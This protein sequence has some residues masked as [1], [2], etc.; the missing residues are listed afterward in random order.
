METLKDMDK[1]REKKIG[2]LMG[3]KS[4]ERPVSLRSGAGVLASLTRQGYDAVGIDVDEN[5]AK[6]LRDEG[7]EVAFIA[8]HGRGGEDGAIQGLLETMEIPYTGSG[9][10]A[11][12]VSMDK[13]ATKLVLEHHG[14]PFPATYYLDST[15][16]VKTQCEEMLA[17]LKLPI[18]AKPADEGSSLGCYVIKTP[19]DAEE[20][21]GALLAEF[22]NSIAEEFIKG[23]DVTIGII[24]A[25]DGARALPILEL[26]PKNEFYDYEAKY[27]KGMTD[28]YC[29]A[30]IDEAQTRRCQ[31][32]ALATH[33]ALGAHG[34]SRVDIIVAPD[35]GC[36]VLELNSIPGMTE[37]S[38][39]PAEICAEGGDYDSLV[40][41]ILATAT[42]ER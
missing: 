24:G 39:L 35:G 34:V 33:K 29:P 30:R 2:V 4:G 25:G 37:L 12:A 19:E 20:M 5:I 31:E 28:F 17:K 6:R 27:T 22:P 1:F 38:D 13:S 42:M 11:S 18:M 36:Y 40:L 9:I 14:I 16:D 32:L 8:L 10:R 41:E 15:R 7:V 21:I 23:K 26:A 3:G